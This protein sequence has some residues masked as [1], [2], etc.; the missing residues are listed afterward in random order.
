MVICIS[1]QLALRVLALNSYTIGFN[2]CL[3]SLVRIDVPTSLESIG[4][5]VIL[6]IM[7][8]SELV[9]SIEGSPDKYNEFVAKA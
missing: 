1:T 9:L 8:L 5:F 7:G 2:V 4:S 3:V 6:R